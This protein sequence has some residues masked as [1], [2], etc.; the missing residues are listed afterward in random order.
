V[1]SRTQRAYGR[2]ANYYDV[3]ENP[4]IALEHQYVLACVHSTEGVRILDAACGTGRY[5]R[6]F[7]AAGAKVVGCEFSQGM[8]E[9]ARSKNPDIEFEFADLTKK[10]PYPDAQFDAV[11]C[12]QAL[13]HIQNIQF[14][15]S[16]FSRVAK[17]GGTVLFSVTHPN[18]EWKHFEMSS[19]PRF[20]IGEESDVY[21]H[22]EADYK[23]AILA[24]D[25]EFVKMTTIPIDKTIRQMLTTESFNTVKGRPMV[26]IFIAKKPSKMPSEDAWQVVGRRDTEHAARF[27]GQERR[28][29]WDG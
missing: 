14:T 20:I 9:V 19:S 22:S 23:A 5:C 6:D 1:T 8:L 7:K 27:A 11:N 13:K 17:P 3:D 26:A 29:G 10:L 2:F 25:L 18:M 21:H 4:L 24:A 16:E 28:S 12:S 15:V